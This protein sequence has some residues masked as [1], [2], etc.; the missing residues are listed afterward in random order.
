MRK[1]K[2]TVPPVIKDAKE[3]PQFDFQ[4]LTAIPNA[5]PLIKKIEDFDFEA[6]SKRLGEPRHEVTRDYTL[7]ACALGDLLRWIVKGD[8]LGAIARRAVA[9]AW[10]INPQIFDGKSA[11]ALER[12]FG[13]ERMAI[14]RHAVQ[15][16][17]VFNLR[18]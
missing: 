12:E 6:V 3:K 13:L 17:R 5:D 9:L 11:R 10:A 15:A 2:I 4:C 7:A 18:N 16:R 8:D 14:A 1:P